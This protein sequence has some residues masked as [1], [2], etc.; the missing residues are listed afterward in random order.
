MLLQTICQPF[1]EVVLS[2]GCIRV[3]ISLIGLSPVKYA[4]TADLFLE[5]RFLAL[6]FNLV[7]EASCQEEI[8]R[9]RASGVE[10]FLS[11]ISSNVHPR[12]CYT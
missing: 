10:A 5:K 6:E 11:R 9:L 2:K 3:A 4:I 1:S 8:S 7:I 12:H